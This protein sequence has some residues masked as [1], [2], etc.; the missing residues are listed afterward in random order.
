MEVDNDKTNNLSFDTL[1]D[2]ISQA[3]YHAIRRMDFKSMTRIQAETIPHGL[4]GKDIVGS[5]K[6][7]ELLI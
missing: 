3:T 4:E 1:K 2:Q 6:T 5:A 7:G